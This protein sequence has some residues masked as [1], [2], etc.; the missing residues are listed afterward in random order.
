MK[1]KISVKN[2]RKL[3]KDFD[4]ND[5]V[6]LFTKPYFDYGEVA[7]AELKVNDKILMEAEGE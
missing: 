2:L 5:V 1:M 6:E 3:L 7:Y 4:D